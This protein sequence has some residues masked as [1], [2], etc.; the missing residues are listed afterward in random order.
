MAKKQKQTDH[1]QK[2]VQR[3]QRWRALRFT[4]R[5]SL[6]R[7]YY[8]LLICSL[9]FLVGVSW[10]GIQSGQFGRMLEQTENAALGK[11]ANA[12]LVLRN[13]YMDGRVHFKADEGKYD[14]YLSEISDALGVQIGDPIFGISVG[15]VQTRLRNIPW[16]RDAIVERQLPDTLHIHLLERAPVAIWQNSGTLRVIDEDGVVLQSENASHPKYTDLLVV[17][18]EDAP[19]HTH[20]LLQM[21]ASE[22]DLLPHVKAAVR[23]GGRRWDIRFDNKIEVKLPEENTEEAWAKFAQME[24]SEHILARNIRSVDLRLDDKLFIDMPEDAGKAISSAGSTKK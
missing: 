17:V 19:L 22:P 1:Y 6:R 5:Q 18:G 12:G 13:I 23:S 9:L 14:P 10:W 21:L 16:I 3:M 8:T 11:T 15:E 2:R 24:R 4:L 7:G 20:E